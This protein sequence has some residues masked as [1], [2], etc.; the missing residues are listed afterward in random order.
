MLASNSFHHAKVY[1]NLGIFLVPCD[2]LDRLVCCVYFTL[3]EV[4]SVILCMIVFT[5]L[6]HVRCKIRRCEK[7]MLK[8]NEVDSNSHQESQR[9][10]MGFLRELKMQKLTFWS[11]HYMLPLLPT[12]H[13]SAV[14]FSGFGNILNHGDKTPDS[15][16]NAID[17]RAATLAS[18]NSKLNFP[19]LFRGNRAMSKECFKFEK[20]CFH[21][22]PEVQQLEL[23]VVQMRESFFS[24]LCAFERNFNRFSD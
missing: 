5:C 10:F 4:I 20:K 8:R 13:V 22:E 16:V 9:N 19:I 24:Y 15:V 12:A 14:V 1:V 23:T 17:C 21:R 3:L 2:R 18:M 7:K 11:F 6:F